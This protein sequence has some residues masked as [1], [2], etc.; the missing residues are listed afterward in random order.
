[1]ACLRSWLSMVSPHSHRRGKTANEG[2][3][4][5]VALLLIA[6]AVLA[7]VPI[8]GYAWFAIKGLGVADRTTTFLEAWQARDYGLVEDL[9]AQDCF[10]TAEDL[11][12]ILG[13]SE[14]SDIDVSRSVQ[15]FGT[16]TRGSITFDD[17][18]V[19]NFEFNFEGGELCGP[20]L[21]DPPSQ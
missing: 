3:S 11:R 20:V 14:I 5:S 9:L 21:W 1:M 13:D 12:A 8:A 17:T 18:R 15:S 7:I 19:Q 2:R 4:F 16:V 6:A 10:Q